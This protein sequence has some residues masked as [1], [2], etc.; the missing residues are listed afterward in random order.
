MHFIEFL[1]SEHSK[2]RK[3]SLEFHII[4]SIYDAT[5]LFQQTISYNNM[6]SKWFLAE[7]LKQKL[8]SRKYHKQGS[9]S[10]II[11]HYWTAST[12]TF[13]TIKSKFAVVEQ[14]WDHAVI[15]WTLRNNLIYLTPFYDL[16]QW[17]YWINAAVTRWRPFSCIKIE[18]FANL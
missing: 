3:H 7:Q 17:S 16:K 10:F 12:H 13:Y 8:I 18:N 1:N 4:L 2:I 11:N 5:T 6:S 15:A 9:N 14:F